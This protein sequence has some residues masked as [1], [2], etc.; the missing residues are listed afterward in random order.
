MSPIQF[1]SQWLECRRLAAGKPLNDAASRRQ[2]GA[3]AT[4]YALIVAMVAIAL[5]AAFAG[6]G[7]TTGLEAAF[8]T[9]ISNVA[10]AIDSGVWPS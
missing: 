9:F 7:S 2:R 1:I 5:T 4:E 3:S 8:A 10:T 6:D